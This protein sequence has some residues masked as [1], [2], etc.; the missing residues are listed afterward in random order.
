MMF[1]LLFLVAAAPIYC[2]MST[3]TITPS[4]TLS[5]Q[6]KNQNNN[7]NKEVDPKVVKYGPVLYENY[8]DSE[9]NTK[10]RAYRYGFQYKE[11]ASKVKTSG[12]VQRETY[13]D[14]KGEKGSKGYRWGFQY[15][16]DSD[17][18]G[19]GT[20]LKAPKMAPSQK[21]SEAKLPPATPTPTTATGEQAAP[22][23]ASLAPSDET[24]KAKQQEMNKKIIELI[25]ERQKL[26]EPAAQNK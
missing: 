3:T 11:D 13:V 20:K 14:E 21:D 26:S 23:S 1:V 10:K 24:T 12:D 7:N 6:N 18:G 9:G 15:S 16:K 4:V 19:Q 22:T 8:V 17:S 5:N 25:K 2:Q